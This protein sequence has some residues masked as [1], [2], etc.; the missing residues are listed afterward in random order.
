MSTPFTAVTRVA[1]EEI[2]K[3]HVTPS[4]YGYFLDSEDMQAMISELSELFLTSR[5][6]KTAGDKVLTQGAPRAYA[7]PTKSTRRLS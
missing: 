6:L 5:A 1:F 7:T 2:V 3:K 4:K